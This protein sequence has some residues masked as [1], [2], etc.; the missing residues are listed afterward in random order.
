VRFSTDASAT[1]QV[2]AAGAILLFSLGIPCLYYGTEQA[3][4]GP[5]KSERD[6]FLPDFGRGA[7]KY[8]RETLFGAEHPRAS[9]ADSLAAGLGGWDHTLP[10]FGAFGIVGCHFFDRGFHVFRRFQAM[11]KLRQ[12]IPAL[13]YGRQYLRPLR[14]FGHPFDWPSAGELIAWSRILDEEEVLCVVNGHGNALRG[15]DVIVDRALNGAASSSFRVLYN[16][17]QIAE[18]TGYAGSHPVGSVLPVQ[19]D[20]ERAWIEIRDVSP[21]EVLVL[22]NVGGVSS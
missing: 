19:T 5:E 22:G 4:A 3:L 8:L 15:G 7:D 2:A 10:G 14:N 12:G 18:G 17:A 6:Q 20:A 9:G 1:H 21:S 11:M 16:S 13:R